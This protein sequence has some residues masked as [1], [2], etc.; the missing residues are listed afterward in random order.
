MGISKKNKDQDR[1]VF[2]PIRNGKVIDGERDFKPHR[3]FG[4]FPTKTA[5]SPLPIINMRSTGFVACSRVACVPAP[6]AAF[7]AAVLRLIAAVLLP[8][9]SRKREPVSKSHLAKPL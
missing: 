7:A 6:D 5:G 8:I 3:H 1:P 4:G 2:V 9:D